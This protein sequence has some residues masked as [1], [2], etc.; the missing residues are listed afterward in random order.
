MWQLNDC[1]P[2]TSW[3]AVDGAGRPKPLWFALRQAFAPRLLTVVERDGATCVAAV[4][5]TDEPWVGTLQVRRE[6]LGGQLLAEESVPVAVDARQVLLHV[7]RVT[8]SAW[9]DPAAEQLVAVLGDAVI[10][11]TGVDDVDL[12]LDPDP[13]EY[14]VERT[15]TGYRLRVQARSLVRDLV[16][17]ADRIDPDAVVSDGLITLPAGATATVEVTCRELQDPGLLLAAPVL[18]T[19][20][21][22]QAARISAVI[23]TVADA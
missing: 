10:V 2:V 9:D 22:L 23:S 20:N 12:A 13:A 1:W 7:V 4:N 8:V 15:A 19:A 18:R 6:T 3:A 11:H 14:A 16:V 17:H 5:D 21:D